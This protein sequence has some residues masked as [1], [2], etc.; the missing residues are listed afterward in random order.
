MIRARAAA[1]FALLVAAPVLRARAQLPSPAITRASADTARWTRVTYVAGRSVY[2][3]AGRDDGLTEGAELTIVRRGAIIATLR[4]T[5]LSPRRASGE[6]VLRGDGGTDTVTVMVGDSARFIARP[7]PA[8]VAAVDS[9]GR[10]PPVTDTMAEQAGAAPTTS[11]APDGAGRTLRTLGIRGRIGL[12]YLIVAQRD[13]GGLRLTQPAADIRVDGQRIGGTPLG[14]SV[15]ARGRR[16]YASGGPAGT[17]KSDARTRVYHLSM[18]LATAGGGRV[19]VGRQFSEAFGNVSLF[20]GIS[21][22]L[23]RRRWGAGMFAGTQPEPTSMSYASDVR[24]LGAYVQTRGDGAHGSWSMTMGAVGSYHASEPNR[25]FAF[26]Q[27]TVGTPRFSLYAVQEVDYN[28]GWKSE[29]GERT[30][31]PT[32]T[33]VSA[34][35]RPVDPLTVAAGFDTRR[36]VRLWRDLLSPETEFDD[37][38]RQGVWGSATFRA[39]SHLRLSADVRSSDGGDSSGT[40]ATAVGGTIGVDR[41]TR[42]LLGANARTT[43]YRSPWLRGWLHSATLSVSPWDGPVRLE[44]EGGIRD[45]R[46]QAGIAVTSAG[47]SRMHWLG[48]STE[49][50]LGRAW[51][52]MLTATRETGGWESVHQV[53]AS[54]TWR[55]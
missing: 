19:A 3:A 15:D 10:A 50:A 1:V 18:S 16:T 35:L 20:D 31:Q 37:R 46:D 21:A 44:A 5:F 47:A 25:E 41:L 54:L 43:R 24:E 36:G 9:A 26:G 28:R 48:L 40:R 55:F 17:S 51:Y 13:S 45:E 8:H 34:Q 38:F 7:V 32:S 52:M 30:L 6:I 33:F 2:V 42:S 27:L 49:A 11:P 4:A 12:R 22:D 14:F 53:Y 23:T 39:G 29:A